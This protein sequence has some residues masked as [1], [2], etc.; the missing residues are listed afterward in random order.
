MTK[1]NSTSG[2]VLTG[3]IPSIDEADGIRVGEDA[4]PGLKLRCVCRGHQGTIGRLA[5]SPCGRFI[6]SPSSDKTIRLWDAISGKCLRIF[7]GHESDVYSIGWTH[8]GTLLVSGGLDKTVRV[9]NVSTGEL[10][11][12]LEIH[13]GAVHSVSPSPNTMIVAS[14]D[15]H[16]IVNVWDA[17]NGALNMSFTAHAPINCVTWLRDAM[18]LAIATSHTNIGLYDVNEKR[19]A[20]VPGHSRQVLSVCRIP[21]SDE[22]DFVSVSE[23]TTL[24][25]WHVDSLRELLTLEGHLHK[26]CSV[27]LSFDGRLVASNSTNEVRIWQ[28]SG[29]RRI[30]FLPEKSHNTDCIAGID[31]HPSEFALATLGEK[32]TVIRVWDL[33]VEII[34]RRRRRR[35]RR[36]GAKGHGGLENNQ[37]PAQVA[38]DQD[39]QWEPYFDTEVLD[40]NLSATDDQD[41]K[42][43]HYFNTE[44][45]QNEEEFED[46]DSSLSYTSAKI[47]LVGESNIGK[48]CLAM[49]IAEDRYPDDHEHGTTHGMRF[50]P[51]DAEQLYPAAKAPDG[52]RR[53]V[54]L[55]DFGGQD[56]YMLVHQMFLHDTTLALVLIDPTRG[57]VALD[58]A[59]EWNKQLEKHLA[60]RRAVK[61]LVGAKQ[62]RASRVVNRFALQE[63]QIECGFRGYVDTSA[64][65]GRNIRRLRKLIA[66]ALDWDQLAKTSR[67]ELF[68]RI[69]DDIERRRRNGDIVLMLEELVMS[70]YDAP[71]TIEVGGETKQVVNYGTE[72]TPVYIE[73]RESA[74]T[75]TDQ[76]SSQGVL[77]QTKLMSG[78]DALVLQLPVIERYAGSLI[79]AAHNNPRG[80]PVLEE[81]LL[82]SARNIPLPGMP[83][84]DRVGRDQE[85]IV[86]ECIVELMIQHGICFRHGGLL[87]FPT[88]FPMASADDERL[89]HS[90]SLFYDFTGAIDNIY[91]SLVAHMMVSEEFG[92][93]RLWAGRVEFDRPSSGLCGIRQIKRTGGLAH[94]DLFFSAETKPEVRDL[95]TRFVEEHLRKT[96]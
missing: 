43:E 48:S 88:L 72:K 34:S 31:F 81:R 12:S 10:V 40:N 84:K 96:V 59:R 26:V 70:L 47:V 5:W 36:R 21:G 58:A 94:I 35:R 89:P 74:R 75:V 18:R 41:S 80:V 17:S 19:Y 1:T 69:R 55:W 45:G 61:L 60:G 6:A 44:F 63:V 78:D 90:I 87:V 11:R 54:V 77:V 67:P 32:G 73:L 85:R 13:N 14:G 64:K 57:R 56:E 92:E 91:A 38:D 27:S 29:G 9:W 82:G 86:L 68:Q 22:A 83:R 33:D 7:E 93:G 30:A 62:D 49:R 37:Q 16:G 53:D 8:G 20:Q 39:S 24:K 3:D 50:W 71:T 51:M 66:E 23:D 2:L 15:R 65:T 76:L 4:R 42:W 46:D 79:V 28:V 25:V 52:Q 95:F